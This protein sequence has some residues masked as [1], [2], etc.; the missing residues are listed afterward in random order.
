VKRLK[1]PDTSGAT[2]EKGQAKDSQ[3][4]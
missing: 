4:Q 1:I 3:V 2:N